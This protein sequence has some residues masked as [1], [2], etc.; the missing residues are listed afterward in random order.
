MRHLKPMFESNRNKIMNFCAIAEDI[1]NY[2]NEMGEMEPTES[3][4]LAALSDLAKKFNMS[5]DDLR[6]AIEDLNPKE[7]K[8]VGVILDNTIKETERLAN[9]KYILSKEDIMDIIMNFTDDV[10]PMNSLLI[11]LENYKRES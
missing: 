9:A 2:E 6:L 5:E 11:T 3:G 8:L 4:I 7:A 1:I 10:I